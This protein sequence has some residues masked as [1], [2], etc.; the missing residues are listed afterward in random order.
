MSS[1]SKPDPQDKDSFLELGEQKEHEFVNEI[2]P[3]LG[4]DAKINPEKIDDPTVIDMIVDGEPADLK[5]QETPFFTSE[6]KFGIEPQWAVTFNKI[7]YERY[8]DKG[9]DMDIIF[10]INWKRDEREK[11]EK[12]GTHVAGMSG[13]WVVPFK[14]IQEWVENDKVTYHKYQNRHHASRNSNR[15]YG[16][17]LRWM[18]CLH[19]VG[20]F[21]E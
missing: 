4:L 15:S 17:D 11:G 8:K 7:D 19:S 5:V 2:A 3:M 20:P 14:K 12:Y 13:V 16:L 6:N 1:E 21:N 10:W 18:E 9:G